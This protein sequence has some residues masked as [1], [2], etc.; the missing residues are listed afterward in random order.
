[1][2]TPS[3]GNLISLIRISIGKGERRKRDENKKRTW[4]DDEKGMQEETQ[5][6]R[7]VN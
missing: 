5:S 2:K 1:M 3:Q 6:D 4:K 7:E